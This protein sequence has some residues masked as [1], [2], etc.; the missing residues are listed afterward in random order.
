MDP[1]WDV[2]ETTWF[3]ATAHVTLNSW[4]ANE[5]K[6]STWFLAVTV[7]EMISTWFPAGTV[8]ETNSTWFPC[9]TVDETNSTWFP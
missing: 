6:N 3:P 9:G 1:C 5:T 2:D 7:D 4:L 8:Y